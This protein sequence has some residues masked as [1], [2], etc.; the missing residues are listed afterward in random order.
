MKNVILIISLISLSAMAKEEK[1]VNIN[2]WANNGF[3]QAYMIHQDKRTKSLQA[4]IGDN[5]SGEQVV[6]FRF[7]DSAHDKCS[8]PTSDS[9]SNVGGGKN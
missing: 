5:P 1:W 7:F 9:L 6:E 8:A 2:S 4:V 3:S